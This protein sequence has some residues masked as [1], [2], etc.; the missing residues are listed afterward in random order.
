MHT[1]TAPLPTVVSQA[2]GAWIFGRNHRPELRS[3]ALY[4]A[5]LG[6]AAVAPAAAELPVLGPACVW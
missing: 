3:A 1:P 6:V 2:A 5:S 4:M